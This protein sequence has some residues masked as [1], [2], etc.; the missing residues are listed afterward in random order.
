MI[1]QKDSAMSSL[2]P[3]T[4]SRVHWTRVDLYVLLSYRR[5]FHL[6]I[7]LPESRW[8]NDPNKRSGAP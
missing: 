2:K 6:L 1:N 8:S 5:T 4:G 3:L 7:D